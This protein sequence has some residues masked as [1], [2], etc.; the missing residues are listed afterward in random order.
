MFGDFITNYPLITGL[1]LLWALPWKGYALWKSARKGQNIWF[2]VLFLVN[3][4][5]ILE[6]LY[7][8]VFSEMENRKKSRISVRTKIIT[9]KKKNVRSRR[10]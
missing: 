8:F 6:I 10:R 9:K 7:I 3:T 4:A 5:A 1:I 2:I